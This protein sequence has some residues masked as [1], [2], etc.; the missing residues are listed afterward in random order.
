MT[1]VRLTQ[2]LENMSDVM[3]RQKSDDVQLS[4]SPKLESEKDTLNS[5]LQTFTERYVSSSDL[6]FDV[7]FRFEAEASKNSSNVSL[8]LFGGE[9]RKILVMIIA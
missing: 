5:A 8:C 4:S 6:S 1:M 2:T 7:A 3:L 9:K